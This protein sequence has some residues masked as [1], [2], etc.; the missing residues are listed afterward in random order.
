MLN[1]FYKRVLQ[2]R[3]YSAKE[4]SNFI[5]PTD[6]SHPIS[7]SAHKH[8]D[9]WTHIHK[10]AS[11]NKCSWLSPTWNLKLETWN[12]DPIPRLGF[13]VFSR[14]NTLV[15]AYDE[16]LFHTEKRSIYASLFL[17]RQRHRQTQ[18]QIHGLTFTR[19]PP[20]TNASDSPTRNL[21]P[22]ARLMPNQKSPNWSI[23]WSADISGVRFEGSMSW[24]L[25]GR[26]GSKSEYKK[27]YPWYKPWVSM[28][29]YLWIPKSCMDLTRMWI[30]H[31]GW[32]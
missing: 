13:F 11:T 18:T 8:T 6:R 21:N 2:K 15:L 17:T 7:V 20:H 22:I 31:M 24:G 16:R 1:L 32:L 10:P 3:Q 19:P 9:S 12:L 30:V 25:K 5:D 4:T 26:P 29:Y 28:N 23:T 14:L 27:F